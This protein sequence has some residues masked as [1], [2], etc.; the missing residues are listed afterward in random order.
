MTRRDV[1]LVTGLLGLLLTL[2]YLR[3]AGPSPLP[4]GA[5]AHRFSAARA[6]TVLAD[7]LRDGVP[8]PVGSN[9]NVAIRERIEHHFRLLGYEAEVQSAFVCNATPACATVQNVFARRPGDQGPWVVLTAHYDSVA[10][11]PGASDDGAGVAA[12]IEVARAIRPAAAI[13]FLITDGEEAG[14]LGAEAFVASARHQ[15]VKAVVNVEYRGTSGPSFLFETSRGNAALLPAIRAI[16][17]PH[18]SSLFYTIYEM[19][20]NDTDVSV[21]KRAGM[22]A[23]NFA[24]IGDVARYHTPLDDLAHVDLRTLQHHGDNLLAAALA[25]RESFNPSPD[26]AVFFDLLGFFVVS[27]PAQ[28]TVAIAMTSLVL[29]ITG[30]RGESW[31]GV[32]AGITLTVLALVLAGL[33]AFALAW[34]AHLR[35]G[36]AGRVAF[37]QPAIVAVWLG[38]VAA[39]LAAFNLTSN[40]SRRALF[41]GAGSTWHLL[42]FVLAV[43]LPGTAFVFLVPAIAFAIAIVARATPLV[44]ALIVSVAAGAIIFPLATFLYPALGKGSL[45]PIAV[46]AA[47]TVTGIAPLYVARGVRLSGG[48]ALSAVFMALL[49]LVFP[50]FTDARPRRQAIEHEISPPTVVAASTRVGD[51]VSI[52]ITSRRPADRL[53]L[54]FTKD[55]EILRVNGAPLAPP[56]RGRVWRG[57]ATIYAR[58]ALVEVRARKGASVTVSDLVYGLP[59]EAGQ[60]ARARDGSGAVTT[61]RGDVTISSID[62]SI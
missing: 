54:E 59:P 31:K 27:W 9:A 7:L 52:R 25:L 37:P 6:R 55:I 12:L 21:F 10:A 11:G 42:A 17:R 1:V 3:L 46:M 35:A 24:A 4:A 57:A 23:M 39:A 34:V 50:T 8:H 36:S 2:V 15:Q 33:F 18:A 19:L 26:D 48:M 41:G 30:L 13:A 44:A 60:K 14:L 53:L 62:L 49:G 20:P 5:P 29:L 61:H 32:F 45:I 56:N 40:Y 16:R 28:W 51:I 58:E 47:A 43:R 38:G 22:Q